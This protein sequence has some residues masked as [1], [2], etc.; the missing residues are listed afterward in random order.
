MGKIKLVAVD[1]DGTLLNDKK[2]KPADFV[3]WVKAHPD[4]CTVIASG[5]QYETLRRDFIELENDLYFLADNGSFVFYRGQMLHTDE[6]E[7]HLLH[8]LLRYLDT[9]NDVHPILCGA[10]SA[11]VRPANAYVMENADM[12]YKKLIVTED[13]DSCIEEDM[14]P[15]VACFY[16][17]DYA[18]DRASDFAALDP[19]MEAVVSGESW[20]DVLHAGMNKGA[21]IKALQE[22]LNIRSEE[23]MAFGD[24]L[25]D[26]AMLAACGESYAMA[27]AH[28]DIIR[29]AKHLAPSNEEEGVMQIL[30]RMD[31]DD[32]LSD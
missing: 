28:P 9:L 19:S 5:R 14:I 15:K 22:K 11:Y 3:P 20:I 21:G 32:A 27:N 2:E 6:I 4:I 18:G 25:N 26:Y 13:L 24:Y 12:Y 1:M 29:L 10:K 31:D 8:E 16:D 23:C 30:R 17:K 7:K